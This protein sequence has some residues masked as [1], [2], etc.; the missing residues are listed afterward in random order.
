MD[1]VDE[2]LPG[3]LDIS[4]KVQNTTNGFLFSRLQFLSSNVK[5]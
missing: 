1:R 5:H 2:A 3:K 4:Q